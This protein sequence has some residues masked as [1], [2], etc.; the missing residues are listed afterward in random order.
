MRW[1][2]RRTLRLKLLT[3]LSKF[4]K[5]MTYYTYTQLMRHIAVIACISVGVEYLTGS[6]SLSFLLLLILVMSYLKWL[7]VFKSVNSQKIDISASMQHLKSANTQAESR[8]PSFEFV[9]KKYNSGLLLTIA[10][11]AS[12]IWLSTKLII[13]WLMPLFTNQPFAPSD[14]IWTVIPICIAILSYLVG[15]DEEKNKI[16]LVSISTLRF[17]PEKLQIIKSNQTLDIP[18][19][20]IEDIHE[21]RTLSHALLKIVVNEE[22]SG[23]KSNYGEYSFDIYDVCYSAA[24]IEQ[25]AIIYWAKAIGKEIKTVE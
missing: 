1:C 14:I 23:I 6:I 25:L 17:L 18:W 22:S 4:R 21:K 3:P 24:D 20:S 2:E 5:A 12:M 11:F 15:K 13:A 10:I 7:G 9:A 16:P 19:Q 8:L